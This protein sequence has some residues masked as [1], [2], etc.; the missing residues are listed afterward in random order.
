[1]HEIIPIRS[2][3]VLPVFGHVQCRGGHPRNAPVDHG[4]RLR[5]F[6]CVPSP[7]NHGG[8]GDVHNSSRGDLRKSVLGPSPGHVFGETVGTCCKLVKSACF[9]WVS[10]PRS[11][12]SGS[13][14]LFGN[15]KGLWDSNSGRNRG[16]LR[17]LRPCRS[18]R[19]WPCRL[20]IRMN[21]LEEMGQAF[22][23]QPTREV[24]NQANHLFWTYYRLCGS[25]GRRKLAPEGNGPCKLTRYGR[26][27]LSASARS[28]RVRTRMPK[29]KICSNESP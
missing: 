25:F 14:R 13:K 18:T 21:T 23:F 15:G 27:R 5:R 4:G 26:L 6:P 3:V 10:P 20:P 29:S 28:P 17:I 1:M 24:D 7:C 8:D 11:V 9:S 22:R 16:A 2:I 12:L 19:S